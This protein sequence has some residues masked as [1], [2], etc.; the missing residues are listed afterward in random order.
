MKIGDKQKLIASVSHKN[1]E[2]SIHYYCKM[3]ELFD[4]LE[5]AHVNIGHKGTRGKTLFCL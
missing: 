3:E 1:D 4:V 5:I 2:S